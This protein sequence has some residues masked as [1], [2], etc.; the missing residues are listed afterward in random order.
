M[1]RAVGANSGAGADNNKGI[2]QY[3]MSNNYTGANNTVVGGHA[4]EGTRTG[5]GNVAIG[6]SAMLG[7]AFPGNFLSGN[8]NVAVGALAGYKLQGASANNTILGGSVASLTFSTGSGNI[9]IGT[10]SRV[11]APTATTSDFLNIGNLIYGTSIGSATVPGNVGVGTSAPG[12]LFTVGANAFQVASNGEASFQPATDQNTPQVGA[13]GE[14]TGFNLLGNANNIIG[15]ILA[16]TAAY[17]IRGESLVAYAG[18]PFAWSPT[19]GG[20]GWAAVPDLYLTCAAA[21]SLRIGAADAVSPIAQT[22]T[23]QGVSAGTTNIA[24]A[25]FTIAG[26]KVP[27]PALAARSSSRPLLRAQPVPRKIR[28]LKRCASLVPD[29]S[30]LLRRRR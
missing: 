3:A 8:N 11:D 12:S 9:L 26:S 28:K 24:G 30:G 10:D 17:N 21:A 1:A 16:G 5:S 25:N 20:T 15:I 22:L 27:A 14:S 29:M 18:Y 6:S 2:G 13:R 4:M 19:A 23:V 7:V